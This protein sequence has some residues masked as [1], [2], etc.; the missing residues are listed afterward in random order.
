MFHTKLQRHRFLN[1]LTSNKITRHP[2]R[3]AR[4]ESGAMII[5]GLFVF[6]AI[7]L[8]SGVV[9]DFM[10]YESNRIRVQSTADRATIAAATLRES[11]DR[12]ALVQEYF[13][14][15]GLSDYLVAVEVTEDAMNSATVRVTTQP[16]VNTLFMR[17]VGVDQLTSSESSA[18]R[19][20]VTNIE[21]S[22]VLDISG[23]MRWLDSGGMPRITR[24]R[25]SAQQFV[26]A[27]LNEDA[28]DV[29]TISIIPYAGT[30]NPGQ[31]VFS[32]LGGT[33][34]HVYSHC[35][36]LPRTVFQNTSLPD[37]GSMPQAPHFM[38]WATDWAWLDW[39]WCPNEANSILYHSSDEAEL[40]NFLTNLRLHDG[41][42]THYGMRWG[43]SLLDP[44]SQWLTAT[45]AQ[46]NA[47]ASV[48]KDRPAAWDDPDTLKVVVLM[49]DGNITDQFRPR[50]GDNVFGRN[51][52]YPTEAEQE[53]LNTTHL[54]A[55]GDTWRSRVST[56]NENRLDF[57]SACNLAKDN[58]VIVYTIAF[59][60]NSA[61]Q[62]EMRNCASSPALFFN[63]QGLDLDTA[64]RA[65]ATSIQSLR[66][67][68]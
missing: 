34:W 35:P 33:A 48:H 45:L 32:L 49:T 68:Q 62:T 41:T 37:V 53:I 15:A 29:T 56:L 18:A 14:V 25:S 57:Y 38:N 22:L 67:I 4:H 26:S 21:I 28:P 19:E 2:A 10:R 39:G 66:L 12:A 1:I 36:D 16:S 64:F 7:L 65:I 27:V 40:H 63:A 47:V 61:G 30:V 8:V 11:G 54:D 20:E 23:S 52:V 17:W 46:Q 51:G 58:G 43:I 44:S 24:L 31:E 13:D 50:R 6:V 5:F 9:V 59:E 55:L 60:T 42:G 3:F